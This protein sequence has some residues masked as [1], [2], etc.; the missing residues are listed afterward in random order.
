MHRL[1]LDESLAVPF[2]DARFGARRK[3]RVAVGHALCEREEVALADLEVGPLLGGRGGHALEDLEAAV[4]HF[5]DRRVRVQCIR[6]RSG[7]QAGGR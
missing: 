2:E 7:A 5:E 1:E 4:D 3:R 6:T